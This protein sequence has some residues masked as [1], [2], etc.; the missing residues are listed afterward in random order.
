MTAPGVTTTTANK[1]DPTD[2]K[3]QLNKVF[4]P[5][6]ESLWTYPKESDGWVHAHNSIRTEMTMLEECFLAIESQA[7]NGNSGSPE[8]EG[9][10]KSN[11]SL[12]E[13][14]VKSLKTIFAA[15]YTHV[16]EHHTNEDAIMTP[17]LEK[18]IQYPAK[19]TD[20]HEGLVMQLEHLNNV[21]KALKAGDDTATTMMSLLKDFRSYHAN[22]KEHLQ[23]EE[24]IG[25]PLMR[26]YFEPAEMAKIVQQILQKT[27]KV[28]AVLHY[29]VLWFCSMGVCYCIIVLTHYYSSSYYY[30][31]QLELGGFIYHM[32]ADRFRSEFMKQEGIPFFVWYLEF[33]SS[34]KLYQTQVIDSVT[35]LKSG[36]EPTS[37]KAGV[38]GCMG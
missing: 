17:A 13:W 29:T 7:V 19:L 5:D 3:Y 30:Y 34:L 33:G 35:A 24:D 11:K 18:R 14:Q 31:F 36:V 26:A 15:H 38:F 23:E 37:Q 2:L 25:L 27:P 32:G 4:Q 28:R 20:D 9:D 6:K 12:Q 21:V 8:Q 10:N 22:M 1:I 16:H